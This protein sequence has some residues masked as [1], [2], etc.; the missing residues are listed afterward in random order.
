MDYAVLTRVTPISLQIS[1]DLFRKFDRS[2]MLRET[3]VVRRFGEVPFP[4][5]YSTAPV[6]TTVCPNAGGRC[7]A[8]PNSGLPKFGMPGCYVQCTPGPSLMPR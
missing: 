4:T 8:A 1:V 2:A 5:F 3:K 6:C 7:E